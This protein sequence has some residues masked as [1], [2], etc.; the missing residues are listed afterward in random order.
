MLFLTICLRVSAMLAGIALIVAQ[1]LQNLEF[2][3][4]PSPSTGLGLAAI[5]VPVAMAITVSVMELARD[6]RRYGFVAVAFFVLLC[7]LG[8]TFVV[9][10]ERSA[11]ARD[12]QAAAKSGNNA[13]YNLAS[14]AWKDADARVTKLEDELRTAR[15]TGCGSTCKSLQADVATAKTEA[16]GARRELA[17]LG[18]PV[19]TASMAQRYG[20]LA[21]IIDTWH[22]VL[23]PLAIEVGALCLIGMA[24][25]R[26][27][28]SQSSDG[29]LQRP[30]TKVEEAEVAI[31]ALREETGGDLGTV[32]EVAS[33]IGHAPTTVHRALKRVS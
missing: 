27:R 20:T 15:S 24:L 10:F 21:A 9:A 26:V 8:H 6:E 11:H 13:P 22:P 32:R 25:P 4:W 5:V 3:G 18:A 28:R 17:K 2:L 14:K 29:Q 30:A 12:V 16:D 7:G 33:R 19:E 1:V 31:R 23:Q